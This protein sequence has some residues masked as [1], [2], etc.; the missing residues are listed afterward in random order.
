MRSRA[1]W[2][3]PERRASITRCSADGE[4]LRDSPTSEDSLRLSHELRRA[5][6]TIVEMTQE[7]NVSWLGELLVI[8]QGWEPA[9]DEVGRAI[10]GKSVGLDGDLVAGKCDLIAVGRP[11]LAN[12]DLVARWQKGS[13]LNAPDMSTFYTPGPKG[14]TDYPA[15]GMPA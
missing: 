8:L 14:F 7:R 6:A 15:L 9:H 13:A 1:R 4:V 11:F 10:P 12:P 5:S 3:S 2:S